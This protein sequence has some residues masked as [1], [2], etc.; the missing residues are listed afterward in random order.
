MKSL[1]LY[2]KKGCE[3]CEIIKKRLNDVGIEF[4]V[5]DIE[6][7]SDFE[8]KTDDFVSVN[9]A[10]SYLDEPKL[11]FMI[12][13]DKENPFNEKIYNYIDLNKMVKGKAR[14]DNA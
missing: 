7:H 3:R 2:T 4:E 10:L 1:R 8:K 11:P 14:N 5:H 6:Y 12:E 13:F 9:A